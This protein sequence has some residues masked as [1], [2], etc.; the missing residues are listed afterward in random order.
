[1]T[2]HEFLTDQVAARVHY[3]HTIF[4][5]QIF[6]LANKI[7]CAGWS[8]DQTA[9]TAEDLLRFERKFNPYG[10]GLEIVSATP[11][12]WDLNNEE[13]WSV[14]TAIADELQALVDG[15]DTTLLTLEEL[16]CVFAQ[17]GVWEPGEYRVDWY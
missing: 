11:F 2:G 8:E 13:D 16:L 5:Y 10:V 17:Y 12:E 3:T 7:L 4:G 15:E 9:G 14:R 6:E 1:M